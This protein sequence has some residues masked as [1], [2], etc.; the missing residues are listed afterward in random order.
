M[1]GAFLV[2][3][4]VS[5][6]KGEKMN[7]ESI[8]KIDKAIDCLSDMVAKWADGN[9]PHHTAELASALAELLKARAEWERSR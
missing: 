1:R 2:V 8:N 3:R 9:C 7:L 5:I 6:K 4:N